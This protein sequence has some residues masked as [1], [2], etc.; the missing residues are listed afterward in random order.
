MGRVGFFT[1]RDS[2]GVELA[3]NLGEG[4]PRAGIRRTKAPANGRNDIKEHI[5]L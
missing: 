4:R 3:R 5:V 1:A 2:V